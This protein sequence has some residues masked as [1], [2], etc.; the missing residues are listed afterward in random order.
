MWVL[1]SFNNFR[2]NNSLSAY[3]YFGTV[4]FS[5]CC[6]T[7]RAITSLFYVSDKFLLTRS[8]MSSVAFSESKREIMTLS[9]PTRV[10]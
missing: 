1:V 7:Q 9:E 5:G 6:S 8:V 3:T 4:D 2:S 10:N